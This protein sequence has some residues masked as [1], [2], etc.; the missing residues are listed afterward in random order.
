MSK[1]LFA[2]GVKVTL[3]VAI[4]GLADGA[5]IEVIVPAGTVGEVTCVRECDAPDTDQGPWLYDVEF[6][7]TAD[8]E[9]DLVWAIFDAS[10]AHQLA[11]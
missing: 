10:D 11:A 1:P 5:D 9:P 8:G 7:V 2:E 4:V 6:P 3:A